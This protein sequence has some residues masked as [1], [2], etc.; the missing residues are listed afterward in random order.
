M[1]DS[2]ISEPSTTLA[3]LI[4]HD[5]HNDCRFGHSSK[6]K[7]SYAVYITL[8]LSTND[9]DSKDLPKEITVVNRQKGAMTWTILHQ[10]NHRAFSRMKGP[11]VYP[12]FPKAVKGLYDNHHQDPLGYSVNEN[13]P[14]ISWDWIHLP[15]GQPSSR[16]AFRLPKTNIFE[17]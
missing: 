5:C 11:A 12:P 6:K 4:S 1:G 8:T 3:L 15:I 2:H 9:L 16:E 17:T 7:S 13:G 10:Q 14:D